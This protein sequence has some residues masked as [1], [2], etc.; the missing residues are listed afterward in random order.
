MQRPKIVSR[1]EWTAARKRLLLKEKEL[2]RQRD[3][4]AAERRTLP[5]VAIEKEYVFQGPEGRRTLADLFEGKRELLVYH[6][7]FGPELGRREVPGLLVRG[8]QLRGQPR[9]PRRPRHGVRRDLARAARQDHALP[10]A[11]GVD[12]PLAVVVRDRLQLRLSGDARRRACRV[13]LRARH[14]ATGRAAAGG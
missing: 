1:D 2:T 9:A 12:L 5:M 8:R 7:M 14:G 3:A 4:L 13:Q 11:D 6:F 10:A